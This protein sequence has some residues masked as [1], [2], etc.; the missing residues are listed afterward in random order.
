MPLNVPSFVQAAARASLQC[1]TPA[2]CASGAGYRR[3]GNA[4]ELCPE[5]L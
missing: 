5:C 2:T 3:A 1:N 4:L